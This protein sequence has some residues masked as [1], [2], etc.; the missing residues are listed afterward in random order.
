MLCC[1]LVSG[2]LMS[3]ITGVLHWSNET[4]LNNQ[5]AGMHCI[6][7]FRALLNSGSHNWLVND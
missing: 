7:M 6:V 1:S 5:C 3:P 4:S 2:W